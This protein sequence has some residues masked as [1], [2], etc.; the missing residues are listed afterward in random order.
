MS[1]TDRR[2]AAIEAR[3]ELLAE[4]SKLFDTLM[5]RAGN[6]LDARIM[7]YMTPAERERLAVIQDRQQQL[8]L[9][10]R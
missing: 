7:D 4:E 5:A 6:N 2:R 8:E 9:E 3:K 1:N 10:S